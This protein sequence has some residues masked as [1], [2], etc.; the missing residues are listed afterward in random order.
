MLRS[1]LLATEELVPSNAACAVTA[2]PAGHLF[3][4]WRARSSAE[5]RGAVPKAAVGSGA[6]LGHFMACGGMGQKVLDRSA[7]VCDGGGS[8]GGGFN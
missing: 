4:A 7:L 5:R 3:I 2:P 6:I 8:R 1:P